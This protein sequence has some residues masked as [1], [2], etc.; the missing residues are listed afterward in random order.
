VE[1]AL[2]Q[3]LTRHTNCAYN[4][5]QQTLFESFPGLFTPDDDLLQACLESYGEHGLDNNTSWQLRDQD[6]PVQRRQDLID[7]REMLAKI[8][9]R[10]GLRVRE[11][12]TDTQQGRTAVGWLDAFDR[13]LYWF[14]PVASAVLSDVLLKGEQAGGEKVIVLPGSRANLVMYK[15]KRDPR[16]AECCKPPMGWHFL[17]FRHLRW[18]LENPLLTRD[19]LAESL[20]LDPLTYS[21]P[22]LRLL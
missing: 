18:Q 1:I 17:K 6:Q 10:L 13:P 11:R 20:E 7:V 16:L 4:D 5:L 19:S 21:T 12:Q 8:G 3:Y 9:E 22:Q 15:L 14:Y 2:V